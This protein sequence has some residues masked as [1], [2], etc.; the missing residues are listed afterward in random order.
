MAG[1]RERSGDARAGA[2][3]RRSDLGCESL[4]G[5][6]CAL[7]IH[8]RTHGAFLD[9]SYRIAKRARGRLPG[10]GPLYLRSRRVNG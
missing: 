1:A 2:A 3:E 5:V 7:T 8:R 9:Q 6:F 4:N 10:D